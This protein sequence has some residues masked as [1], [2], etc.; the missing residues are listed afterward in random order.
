MDQGRALDLA[1]IAHT[2]KGSVGYFEAPVAFSTAQELEQMGRQ[3]RLAPAAETLARLVRELERVRGD[4]SDWL[5]QKP[6]EA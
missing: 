5:A 3:E 1:T 6:D 4:L 2:I